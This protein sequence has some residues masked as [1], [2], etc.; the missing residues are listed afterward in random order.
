MCLPIYKQ[1]QQTVDFI[2]SIHSVNP[3]TYHCFDC[4]IHCRTSSIAERVP[5]QTTSAFVGGYTGLISTTFV[6]DT[7]TR[8]HFPSPHSNSTLFSTPTSYPWSDILSISSQYFKDSSL[9]TSWTILNNIFGNM[10]IKC[11]D[12]IKLSGPDYTPN[13]FGPCKIFL[14]TLLPGSPS[15]LWPSFGSSA[16]PSTVLQPG[17]VCPIIPHFIISAYSFISPFLI[18]FPHALHVSDIRFVSCSLPR[19]CSDP[20]SPFHSTSHH[21]PLFYFRSYVFL[22]EPMPV[23]LDPAMF[24][25]IL[26]RQ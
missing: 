6:Y 11:Q 4:F 7:R 5:H 13:I 16:Q 17:L 15:E 24:L 26:I 23:S 12:Y 8:N 2:L 21:V 1:F 14:S 20:R 9:D 10:Y 22:P 18:P 25:S 19:P 3:I